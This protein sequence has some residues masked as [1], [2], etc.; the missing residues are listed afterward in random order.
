MRALFFGT[1]AI[2]VPALD[3]LCS[4][5]EV[6]AVVCQ[7]DRPAG[8]GLAEQQP[9]V[10]Q[11]ALELGLS[12][13]QPEKVRPPEFSAWV[14]GLEPDVALVMAYGKIFGASLLAA[15][16]RGCINLHASLLPRW[17]GAAPIQWAIAHG[18][19]ETGISLMQMDAGCDTGPVYSRHAIPIGADETA[20]EL[21]AR[22]AELAATVVRADLPRAVGGE[23][24]AVPQDESAATLAP[25]LEKKDGLLNFARSARVVHD[26]ARGMN[27]W[28]GAFAFLEG[29]RFKFLTTRLGSEAGERGE[30]GTVLS[31]DRTA[32]EIACGQGTL[33]L[34][35]GQLE[36]KKALD[37]AQL[38]AGRSL[39]AGMRFS[40]Q[41][42]ST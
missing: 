35:R 26:R 27:P 3:A 16:R 33:L 8:R 9:P 39:F 13:V 10:K 12:V 22:L 30:P 25:I 31:V 37:A 24:E 29:K 7:P 5:A 34:V 23:L 32:A 15:P 41:S 1:P 11:R 14:A 42:R 2:A 20:A 17:R 21:S 6:V 38:A 18:D 36:G 40:D 4:V 28:P 19:A